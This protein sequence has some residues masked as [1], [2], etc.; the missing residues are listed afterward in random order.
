LAASLLVL[1]SQ[2]S[3]WAWLQSPYPALQAVRKHPPPAQAAEPCVNAQLLPQAPQLLGSNEVLVHRPPQA[4]SLP[5]QFAWQTPAMQ[6]WPAPQA[7][8][9]AP[10]LAASVAKFAQ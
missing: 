9:Q 10:Q 1:V 8:P 5:E 4:V 7:L 3:D 2:P 6:D